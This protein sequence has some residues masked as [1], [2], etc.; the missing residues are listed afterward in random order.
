MNVTRT[1]VDALNAT[2]NVEVIASDYQ[3]KIKA[4]LE[5]YRKTAKIPGF[6]PGHVPLGL[7]QKQYG[8][9]VLAEELNKIVNDAL[10]NY[11][12]DNNIEILGNPIPKEGSDVVGNFDNPDNF[13]FEYE[14]GLAPVIDLT[15]ISKSS[16]DFNKVNVDNDLIDKQ[17]NDLRRRYGKLISVESVGD[18][19]LVMAQFIELDENGNH[20]ENGINHSSTVSIEFIEDNQTQ[21]SLIGRTKGESIE[22]NPYKVSKGGKDTASMLGISEDNLSAISEKFSMTINEIKQ[23]EL[24]ELTQDLF[25]KLFG[26]EAVK[27][28]DELRERIKNDLENMFLQDSDRLFTRDV[29]NYILENAEISLPNDFLKRWIALSNEKKISFDQIEAEYDAYAKSLKWQLI[30]SYIFKT[31]DIKLNNEEVINFTKGLL[32]SNYA[33]YGIPAPEDKELTNSAIQVLSNKDEANRIYDMLAEK[34][35]TDYFKDTIKRN[36][37]LISYDD[38]IALASK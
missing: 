26:P 4:S 2:L 16:F 14:I 13:Q 33:Q 1:N 34:K 3:E 24:A 11:I 36:D 32:I 9:S 20:K 27:S 18:K 28:E 7:I 35:L 10:Y 15:F 12:K 23:M 30:Q 37:K 29:Y 17:I 6:R 19:D 38:F 31:N 5:K 25:D 8:K 22:V 21:K